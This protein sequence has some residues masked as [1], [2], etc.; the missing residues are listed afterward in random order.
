[1]QIYSNLFKADFLSVKLSDS[2]PYAA[3][4]NRTSLKYQRLH[5][6]NKNYICTT[7]STYLYPLMRKCVCIS[8]FLICFCMFGVNLWLI[9]SR[10]QATAPSAAT[11]LF[12]E[13]STPA[14]LASEF[15][16]IYKPQS[17]LAKL[18]SQP[19]QCPGSFSRGS[20]GLPCGFAPH[21][22]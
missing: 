1:M 5:K 13:A 10:H 21:S 9:H 3:H 22:R 6:W 8:L 15:Q 4:R 11:R 16:Y 19:Q 18:L 17:V 2:E 14:E 7:V 20:T 12:Q